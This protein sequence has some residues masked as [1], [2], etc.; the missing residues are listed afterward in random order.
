MVNGE[1][2]N[3]NDRCYE[4]TTLLPEVYCLHPRLV[5]QRKD[6]PARLLLSFELLDPIVTIDE[7]NHE[8]AGARFLQVQ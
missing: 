4:M 3:P 5:N 8:I 1:G 6:D 7:V 2:T